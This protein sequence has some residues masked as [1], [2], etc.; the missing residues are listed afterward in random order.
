MKS[1]VRMKAEMPSAIIRLKKLPVSKFG[2]GRPL[3]PMMNP[4]GS[5]RPQK[6]ILR[7]AR[8]KQR[9]VVAVSAPGREQ[10]AAGRKT[11]TS[12]RHR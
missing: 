12:V 2:A 11:I 5:C 4:N 8:L 7:R 9:S 6:T 1:N 3:L 10:F